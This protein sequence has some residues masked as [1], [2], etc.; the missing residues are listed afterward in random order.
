[1]GFVKVQVGPPNAGDPDAMFTVQYFDEHGNMTIRSGGSRA[2]RCNN[3]GNLV[4]SSYS[5]GKDRRSIRVAGDSKNTYAVYPDYDT[6]HEALVVMLRGS[7][8]GPLTLREAIVRFDKS[9]IKYIE[10]L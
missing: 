6:G 7:K 1:M 10:A 8:Y 3:P 9:N 2:W 5:T 4:A